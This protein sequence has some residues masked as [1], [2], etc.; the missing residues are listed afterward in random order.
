MISSSGLVVPVVVPQTAGS[1]GYGPVQDFVTTTSSTEPLVPLG[2]DVV[3]GSGMLQESPDGAILPLH[4]L[5]APHRA[6]ATF[7]PAGATLEREAWG[8]PVGPFPRDAWVIDPGVDF[9]W[10]T[11]LLPDGVPAPAVWILHG[12]DRGSLADPVG[13]LNAWLAGEAPGVQPQPQACHEVTDPAD[14]GPTPEETWRTRMLAGTW[15]ELVTAETLLGNVS[16]HDENLRLTIAVFGPDGLELP[17]A[18]LLEAIGQVDPTVMGPHPVVQSA[19]SLSATVPV[20]MYLRFDTWDVDATSADDRKGGEL[21]LQPDVVRVVDDVTGAEI[22]GSTWTWVDP[23]GILEIG[24]DVVPVAAF[25]VEAEFAEGLQIRLERG[26]EQWWPAAS[27]DRLVWSTAGWTARDTLTHGTWNQ[28]RG[29]QVGSDSAPVSFWVGTKVRIAFCYQQQWRDR[30]GGRATK[31]RSVSTR[32]VAPGHEVGLFETYLPFVDTFTTDEDG[33]VSGVSFAVNAGM[34][35]GAAVHRR[36]A[37]T[38]ADLRVV[39]DPSR[40]STMMFSDEY[41]WSEDG[42]SPVLFEPFTS[43]SFATDPGPIAVLIDADKRVDSNGNTA[44]AAA[45]HALKFARFAH[46]AMTLLK[47]DA[48]HLPLENEFHFSVS[49]ESSDNASATS[50]TPDPADP[51]HVITKI[52][53]PSCDWFTHTTIVHEYGHVIARWLSETLADPAARAAYEAGTGACHQRFRDEWRQTESWHDVAVVTNGGLA[54]A[55]AIPLVLEL[56]MGLGASLPSAH[57]TPPT[58]QTGWAKFAHDVKRPAPGATTTVV[59]LSLYCG[60]R[61]EGVFAFALHDYIFTVTGFGGFPVV[62]DDTPT[63]YRQPTAYLDDWLGSLPAADRTARLDQLHRLVGW[64]YVDPMRF[65]MNYYFGWTGIWPEPPATGGVRY[66]T[67]YDLLARI[68]TRDPARSGSPPTPEES[69]ARL[70]DEAL[71]PWN[72]EQVRADEPIP[73][74]LDPDWNP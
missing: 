57:R 45:F 73:P 32:R 60:R 43:G 70:H 18:A 44:D 2:V 35:L 55:E 6:I 31:A 40:P 25:H 24:R 61:V 66:A 26:T 4:T 14:R 59:A 68:E 28:F 30:F 27:T 50:Y 52:S 65:V 37:V 69:F 22:P 39:E 8:A 72:L 7:L 62:S 13:L 15:S 1:G 16:V 20:R 51:G 58:G 47:G 56:F 38:G 74:V 23:H 19:G 17:A 63:G 49:T 11:S 12:V 9:G 41:F 10:L 64:L 29:I 67:V 53:L 3:V 48:T 21:V 36:L 34:R 5:L 42:R 46:D 54:R 71:M 33:E